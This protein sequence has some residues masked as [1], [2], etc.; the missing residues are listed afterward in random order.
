MAV[1]VVLAAALVGAAVSARLRQS[2]ILGYL[3]V[4]VLLGWLATEHLTP[5]YG[6]QIIDNE[7]IAMLS[8][9]GVAFLLFFVGLE[10][11]VSRLRSAGRPAAVLAIADVAV[12][13][14]SGTLLGFALGWSLQDTLFL[15]GILA[16]SSV[17]VAA[18]SL[19]DMKRL[20]NDETATLLGMMIV[21]DF[22]TMIILAVTTAW[23]VG[24]SDSGTITQSLQAVAIVYGA[25][26]ALAL[27]V[28][29]RVYRRIERVR[30][31]EVFA[32][33]ALGLI[34]AS[35][36]LAET[37]GMPFIIGTFF[38]GMSF[39]ETRLSERL[40]LRLSTMRD[41]FVG[42]FF[43]MFGVKIQLSTAADSL[44]IVAA[45][46]VLVLFDE[47][48][49][50]GAMSV[51]IG[52]KGRAAALIGAS[53]VGRGE[54]SI[55]FANIGAGLT[56]PAGTALAG[57]PVLSRHL[58]L[59]P[60]AGGVSLVTSALVPVALKHANA[61]ARVGAALIPRSLTHST[62]VVGEFIRE[63]HLTHRH[64][65]LRPRPG[66]MAW[67]VA[68]YLALVMATLLLP[69]LF[70]LALAGA[71]AGVAALLARGFFHDAV[72]RLPDTRVGQQHSSEEARRAIARHMAFT[73]GALFVLVDLIAASFSYDPF[74]TLAL[75]VLAVIAIAAASAR[76][77]RHFTLVRPR[78]SARQLVAAARGVQRARMRR[79]YDAAPEGEGPTPA[80]GLRSVRELRWPAAPAGGA[81]PDAGSASLP[82]RP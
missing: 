50:L 79:K 3:A 65:G 35:A 45:A 29:P 74:A 26:I 51:F 40:T 9:L 62:G 16:M 56:H 67:G 18:K 63:A 81:P 19:T 38:I 71:G 47:V 22:I 4:G 39:A 21:E 64:T 72:D 78:E 36:A 44:W 80:V 77:V 1:A 2:A 32:L 20:A 14:F 69:G 54:D 43:L 53:A 5:R 75:V 58:E 8:D 11:S 37:Y 15:A 57:T 66:W 28:V 10:V 68:A 82:P 48:F 30:N 27:V 70:G 23:A 17:G 61:L 55:I 59:Y 76:S 46:V 13:Y 12:L 7:S 73:V 6:I 60:I 24:A 31:D 42:V 52:F 25:L 33:L 49:I 41:A 34:F